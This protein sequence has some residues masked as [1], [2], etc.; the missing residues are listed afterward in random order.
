MINPGK[1]SGNMINIPIATRCLYCV[2]T[3]KKQ[4]T[5]NKTTTYSQKIKLRTLYAQKHTP[6]VYMFLRADQAFSHKADMQELVFLLLS[7]VVKETDD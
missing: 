5:K 4:K 3:E 1:G 2:S 6:K 7:G